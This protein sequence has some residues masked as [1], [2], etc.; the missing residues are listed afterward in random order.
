MRTLPPLVP[1]PCSRPLLTHTS[2]GDSW[3]LTGKSGSVSFWV[4]APFSW[5]L[6]HKVLFLLSKSISQLYVSSGSFMVGLM[7]TSSKRA[8]AIPRSAEPRA[9]APECPAVSSRGMGQRWPAAWLGALSAAVCIWD[10]LKE[11]AIIFITST[12]VWPQV[13]Q[14]VENT[15]LPINRKLD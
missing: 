8:Y 12:I 13:K 4:T 2:P 3:T 14:Q 10:L 6:V 7:A 15:A 11:I 9:P 1:R 5:V